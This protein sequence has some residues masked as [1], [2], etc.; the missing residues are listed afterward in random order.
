MESWKFENA[1][2]VNF[3]MLSLRATACKYGESNDRSENSD[4]LLLRQK[5]PFGEVFSEIHFQTSRRILLS[6]ATYTCSAQFFNARNNN[7]DHDH[8]HDHDHNHNHT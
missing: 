4:F 7:Y 8:D 3:K 1:G 2:S 6:F 5:D